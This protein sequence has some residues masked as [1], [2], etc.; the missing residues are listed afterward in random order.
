MTDSIGTNNFTSNVQISNEEAVNLESQAE[1]Q[2]LGKIDSSTLTDMRIALAKGEE[3]SATDA[4]KLAA[5]GEGLT[6]K[7]LDNLVAQ[8]KLSRDGADLLLA[9]T[10]LDGFHDGAATPTDIAKGLNN[11]FVNMSA[12]DRDFTLNTLSNQGSY[13]RTLN[14]TKNADGTAQLGYTL[15]S[16]GE[17]LSPGDLPSTP[18][19]ERALMALMSNDFKADEPGAIKA[20]TNWEFDT[21]RDEMSAILGGLPSYEDMSVSQQAELMTYIGAAG[22]VAAGNPYAANIDPADIQKKEELEAKEA[23]FKAAEEAMEREVANGGGVW[24]KNTDFTLSD[25]TTTNL[26]DFFEANGIAHPNIDGNFHT[27]RKESAAT[28]EILQNVRASNQSE[29]EI[30]DLKLN[31]MDPV[32]AEQLQANLMQQRDA[33]LA[34][35]ALKAFDADHKTHNDETVKEKKNFLFIKWTKESYKDTPMSLDDAKFKNSAGEEVSLGDYLRDNNIPF[36]DDTGNTAGMQWNGSRYPNMSGPERDALMNS[37]ENQVKALKS[38]ATLI[39]NEH[40]ANVPGGAEAIATVQQN[41]DEQADVAGA[42]ALLQMNEA[43]R[44]HFKDDKLTIFDMISVA[45]LEGGWEEMKLALGPI[46]TNTAL[47]RTSDDEQ[48]SLNE[49]LKSQGIDVPENGKLNNEQVANVLSE[50]ATKL[51]D[52]EA[53]GTIAQDALDALEVPVV[54]DSVRRGTDGANGAGG[55]LGGSA[56]A[57]PT[58]G[59]VNQDGVWIGYDS[60]NSYTSGAIVNQMAADNNWDSSQKQNFSAAVNEAADQIQSGE[61]PSPTHILDK[62]GLSDSETIDIGLLMFVVQSERIKLLGDQIQ[63]II[64]EQRQNTRDQQDMQA[65][66]AKLNAS[67]G[68]V[69]LDE[70]SITKQDGTSVTLTDFFNDKGVDYSRDG[71]DNILNKEA[72]DLLISNIKGASEGLSNEGQ[73][74]MN[75]LTMLSQKYQQAQSLAMNFLEKFDA[76]KQKIIDKI[77]AN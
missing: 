39:E 69:N 46:D 12:E 70:M 57:N 51:E 24:L 8:G 36:P 40:K 66:M 1:D 68:T 44:L 64:K 16:N 76:M 67:D 71:N 33:E 54:Q 3:L 27:G 9:A 2:L 37:L 53:E 20:F 60:N 45:K 50:L 59:A 10:S 72:K 47:F 43:D 42:I 5:M 23:D 31:G 35:N 17:A 52:L 63:D 38:E 6:A 14:V 19:T 48:V 77:R 26:A 22:Q 28:L 65:A 34:M 18:A 41:M 11:I 13:E 75:E 56:V 55:F 49:F 29:I 32:Q 61:S 30:L 25:G 74:I 7:D 4:A 73:A 62:F 15:S 58:D 21:S